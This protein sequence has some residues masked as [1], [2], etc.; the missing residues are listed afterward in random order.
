MPIL[1]RSTIFRLTCLIST[2]NALNY[3][4]LRDPIVLTVKRENAQKFGGKNFYASDK[5]F[6]MEQNPYKQNFVKAFEI[7]SS[8]LK[9]FKYSFNSAQEPGR[10]I[11]IPPQQF[12]QNLAQSV[13]QSHKNVEPT[14][15]YVTQQQQDRKSLV[16]LEDDPSLFTNNYVG[17]HKSAE[18]NGCCFEPQPSANAYTGPKFQN[19][20]P[21]SAEFRPFP[22]QFSIPIKSLQQFKE[23]ENQPP[24]STSREQLRHVIPTP[25]STVLP[26]RMR[27][28]IIPDSPPPTVIRAPTASS[29]SQMNQKT[30]ASSE[31]YVVLDRQPIT[32]TKDVFDWD[33]K[34]TEAE[35]VAPTRIVAPKMLVH[36]VLPSIDGMVESVQ[37]QNLA[38]QQ[39]LAGN[40]LLDVST[41]YRNLWTSLAQNWHQ[42]KQAILSSGLDRDLAQIWDR[43]HSAVRPYISDFA[44]TFARAIKSAARRHHKRLAEPTPLNAKTPETTSREK[45]L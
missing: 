9:P 15:K 11:I 3:D 5:P 7:K 29:G 39:R 24:V 43:F 4:T 45:N 25:S 28:D 44:T 17:A 10:T 41:Q 27:V 14:K 35:Y 33:P 19:T 21:Q 2:I 8:D 1:L 18:K 20:P 23:K 40:G 16:R 22:K 13:V 42:L 34:S 32:Y 12:I 26:M 38:D 36:P 30:S 31:K 6:N 37:R